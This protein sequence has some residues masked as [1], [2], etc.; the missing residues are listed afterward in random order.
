MRSS[1]V[2]RRPSDVSP[3]RKT[4]RL[5]QIYTQGPEHQHQNKLQRDYNHSAS[6]I[7][8]E[9][10]KQEDP[11]GVWSSRHCR[12]IPGFNTAS[13]AA[14]S[15]I[16]SKIKLQLKE[17]HSLDAIKPSLSS[18][19]PH[20]ALHSSHNDHEAKNVSR[21]RRRERRESTKAGKAREEALFTRARE[22][23]QR[24]DS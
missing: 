4:T 22:S 19:Q 16:W 1:I 20:T 8:Q 21:T 17:Q 24:E 23:G 18:L 3:I 14:Q 11:S 10:I 2:R 6:Y 15:T 7:P 13:P 5:Q 9:R 12:T